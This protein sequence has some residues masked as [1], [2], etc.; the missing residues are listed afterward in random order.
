MNIK[1]IT[2]FI[3]QNFEKAVDQQSLENIE[4]FPICTSF[5]CGSNRN[6]LDL[7]VYMSKG[8]SDAQSESVSME[9]EIFEVLND[10]PEGHKDRA[11]VY[12]AALEDLAKKI[13]DF[14]SEQAHEH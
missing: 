6:P 1:A 8:A 7:Y 2:S 10:D 3:E 5:I 14:Y 9:S 12:A 4:A 13:R 11:I